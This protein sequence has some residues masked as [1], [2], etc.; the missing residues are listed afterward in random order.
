MPTSA[1][2]VTAVIADKPKLTPEEL[3]QR[4]RNDAY[5]LGC[6]SVFILLLVIG[7]RAGIAH[8]T[9]KGEGCHG[10]DILSFV[11]CM[12]L[13][14]IIGIFWIV[15]LICFIHNLAVE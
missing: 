8:K 9:P 14:A 12:V 10:F 11:L 3:F 4:T 1:A 7:F 6:A 13:F 5:L 2:E 15:N